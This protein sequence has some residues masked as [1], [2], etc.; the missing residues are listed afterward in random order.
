METLSLDDAQGRFGFSS[1]DFIK[2]DVE[3]GELAILEGASRSLSTAVGIKVEGAFVR[4]RKGQPVFW[5]AEEFLDASGDR[6]STRGG[7]WC[8]TT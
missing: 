7:N 1:V 4:L 8:L 5:R 3:D 6:P 2:L